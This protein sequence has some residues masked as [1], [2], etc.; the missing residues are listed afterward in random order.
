LLFAGNF[1][2]FKVI[3]AGSELRCGFNASLRRFK[4]A[5]TFLS[6]AAKELSQ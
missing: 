5:G 2:P 4:R 1:T 6:A 3:L